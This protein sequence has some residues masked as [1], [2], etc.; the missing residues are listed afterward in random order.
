M[1]PNYSTGRQWTVASR[2]E[3]TYKLVMNEKT[4]QGGVHC[5]FSFG[6][7][8]DI[9]LRYQRRW[10]ASG[11]NLVLLQHILCIITPPHIKPRLDSCRWHLVWRVWRL[12]EDVFDAGGI[13]SN[14]LAF[15]T[16]VQLFEVAG[17]RREARVCSD[18][19]LL[20]YRGVGVGWGC[21]FERMAMPKWN[22]ICKW[23]TLKVDRR[24]LRFSPATGDFCRVKWQLS[25]AHF[26]SFSYVANYSWLFAPRLWWKTMS[27]TYFFDVK[28]LK[29][30]S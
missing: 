28:I 14:T 1:I 18:Q 26:K 11:F 12:I 10:R 27:H 4:E 6:F 20:T 29:K 3:Q 7:P 25:Q 17:Q 2:L 30:V 22:F 5:Q 19:L 9:G 16:G 21:Y 23:R 8:P 13:K 24:S 15:Q